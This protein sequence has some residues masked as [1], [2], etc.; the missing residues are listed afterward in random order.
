MKRRSP[1]WRD[2]LKTERAQAAR[3]DPRAPEA[4]ARE[5]LAYL[6]RAGGLAF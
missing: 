3:A 1:L 2:E 4:G 5:R 6:I